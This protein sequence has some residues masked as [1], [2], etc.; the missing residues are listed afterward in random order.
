[1]MTLYNGLALLAGTAHQK[2]AEDISTILEQPLCKAH[3]GRFPDGE[4]DVKLSEDVRGKDVFIVQPTCPP[5]NDNLVELL[6]LIDC[7]RRSSVGRI[8]AVMPYFGYARKD[9]K[10]EG[11]VPIT[12]KLVA[13]LLAV[14]GVD[15]V[16]AMDLHAPQIQGF[17]NVPVDHLYAKPVFSKRFKEFD[18]DEITIVAP[19]AGGIKMARAF[20]TMLGCRFAIVDKR[21]MGPEQTV[22]EHLIGDVAGRD[23]V[24]VD[25]MIATGG[26]IVAAARMVKEHGARRIYLAATH[27]VFAGQALERLAAAAEEG[28]V[29]K[30]FVTDTVCS[31]AEYPAAIEVLSV[32]SLLAEAIHRIHVCRSVSSLFVE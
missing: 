2:L 8:T 30:V 1:V 15:R 20:S 4:V 27:G 12:A 19:D 31:H 10:D 9:R 21:R 29:E 25:D 23:A 32:A 16:I 26:T 7:C 18:R 5:V 6:T 17:F 3:V 22:S 14:A 24:L 28:I 11:R 13:D